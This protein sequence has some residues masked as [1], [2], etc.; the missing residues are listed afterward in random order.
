MGTKNNGKKVILDLGNVVLEWNVER[1]LDSLDLE[2]EKLNLLR[3][4]LFSHQDWI[5]LDHGKTTEAAVVSEISNR[6]PLNEETVWQAIAAAR[7]SLAP[8]A[9]TLSLMREIS[10]SGIEMFCLS[11]MSRETYGHIRNRNFFEMF[12]GIIISGV[13][14]CMK[15]H[16]EIFH[17]T[18]NRFGLVPSETIFVDDSLPNIETAQRLGINGLHFKRSKNCYQEIREFLFEGVA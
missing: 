4:E 2:T 1:I 5:D 7:N 11:N 13:E 12:D 10:D 6:S 3:N 14:E 15:P 16:E 9:E 17:L 18:I 8:I